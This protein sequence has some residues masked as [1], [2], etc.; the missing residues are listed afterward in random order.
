MIP[1]AA[2]RPTLKDVAAAAH[3]SVST[4][5]YAL[6]DASRVRLAAETRS[7]IRRI[8]KELGYTPNGIARSLQSR[9]SRSIG[10]VVS[11]PL[12]FLRYAAIV[13]GAGAAITGRGFRMAVLPDAS[14]ASFIDDCRSGLLDGLIFIGHDDVSVPDLLVEAAADGSAPLVT[15]DAGAPGPEAPYS[16]VD[17]DYAAGAES[18]VQELR[19]RGITTVLHLRPEVS[20]RAERERQAALMRALGRADRLT[21]QVVSTGLRD[22]E[23]RQTDQD[24]GIDR[25]YLDRLTARLRAALSEAEGPAGS[26]AVLCSWGADVE[27]A[28]SVV[29]AEFPGTTVGSLASGWPRIELWERLVYSALPLRE[30]GERAV[31]LLAGELRPDARHEHVMLTPRIQPPPGQAPPPPC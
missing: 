28:L 23:L 1:R 8:A 27:A 26:T 10:V 16:S 17:F 24:P 18:M 19:D 15:I 31:E 5:S 21:L 25:A 9:S 11:K 2:S 29:T 3:V 6:N 12:T 13:Q 30:A 20:S 22:E 14:G 7:R 4:V